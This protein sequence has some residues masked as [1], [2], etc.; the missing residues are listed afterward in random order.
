MVQRKKKTTMDRIEKVR[1]VTSVNDLRA[2]TSNIL[3]TYPSPVEDILNV[4]LTGLD[5]GSISILTIEGKLLQEH[6]TEGKS[7]IT[8]NLN[9][10]SQGLYLCRYVNENEIK[11]VKIIKQ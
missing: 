5:A 2:T 3:N 4:D 9:Q 6:K 8:L 1:V 10:L 11:T 7:T